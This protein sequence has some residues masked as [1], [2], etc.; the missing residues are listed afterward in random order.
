MY[1]VFALAL[2]V[3][4]IELVILGMGASHSLGS[5]ISNILTGTP[6]GKAMWLMAGGV[7]LCIVALVVL[8]RRGRATARSDKRYPS[9]AAITARP[10]GPLAR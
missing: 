6:T 7:A 3:G 8:L 2:L 9:R 5:D 4:G 10:A 1:K